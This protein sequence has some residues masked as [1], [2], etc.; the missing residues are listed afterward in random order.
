MNADGT[1]ARR[2]THS[3][4]FDGAGPWSPDGRKMLFYSQRTGGEVW[5]MNADGS[6]QRNL[7]RNRA[8]DS[9]GAWSPDGRKI[10]FTTNRDGN[11]E[12]YVMN[13]DGS[14]QRDLVPSPSSDE[15]AI[16]WAS[17]ASTVLFATNRDHNWEI[18]AADA[19][20]SNPRNLTKSPGNDG[21][22]GG[23]NSLVSPDG[24]KVLFASARDT[25][26]EDNAELYVMNVDGSG[27]QRITRTAGT[28]YPLS[29]SPDG[30]KIAFGRYPSTPRWAF[31]VMNA[32]GSGV[33][34][35]N[36]ALPAQKRR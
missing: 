2:L 21:A 29:W 30:R 33:H 9:P 23:S 36:W 7:S 18:Y 19:D 28:E 35:V 1:G 24:T 13:A 5:V 32:D 26:D 17:G 34:K 10:L 11:A 27:L 31:Y 20:G 4:K 12:V 25:H 16:G 15:T 8:Y 22:I 6:G 14:G 3:P